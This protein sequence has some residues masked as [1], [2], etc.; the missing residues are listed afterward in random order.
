MTKY[1]K[2]K[3]KQ[4]WI[5]FSP[6][7]FGCPGFFRQCPFGQS[8]GCNHWIVLWRYVYLKLGISRDAFLNFHLFFLYFAFTNVTLKC[9]NSQSGRILNLEVKCSIIWDILYTSPVYGSYYLPADSDKTFQAW[10]CF[11][12]LSCKN[13]VTTN[14]TNIRTFV[15]I[16]FDFF[17]TIFD[18]SSL[19]LL[20]AIT[21]LLFFE[22]WF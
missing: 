4:N 7:S 22:Q 5:T 13:A 1:S 8:L 20:L 19:F 12:N 9:G 10:E 16:N 11:L 3:E 21:G 6:S 17:P 18:I 2:V 15:I 14:L